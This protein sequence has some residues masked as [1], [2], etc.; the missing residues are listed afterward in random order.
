VEKETGFKGFMARRRGR[1][2]GEKVARSLLRAAGVKVPNSSIRFSSRSFKK[3][4][5]LEKFLIFLVFA[6]VVGI[7]IG[8]V[9]PK[10]SPEVGQ[11]TGSYHAVGNAAE[12]L[13]TLKIVDRPHPTKTYNR[14][15]FG[16]Q[17]TDEDG[18]GC[19]IRE[20]VL[21]RDL[22][23]VKYTAA[24]SCKVKTGTLKDPYT[25]TTI[26]FVRGV[27]TSSRVQIDHVVA[28]NNAW[29]SGAYSWDSA[30]LYK[31]GNDSYNMLAVDGPA[32]EEKS[33]ASAAYWLP[34][35]TAF[36]CDYVARQI[37][38]KAKYKLTV[39]STEKQAMLKVL[40]GCP[41]EAVP[42]K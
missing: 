20:D 1:S 22:T 27:K 25:G 23:D 14:E 26:H 39:T 16:Y 8:V 12:T 29:E 40:H 34:E 3:K 35:N 30:Q 17:K 28:L 38:V 5:G 11:L 32:N 36:Q 37:G 10:L 4:N 7:F 2:Q 9:L 33:D 13:E 15:L 21:A 42:T 31:Y 18:D 6:V 41:G 19:P 24:G